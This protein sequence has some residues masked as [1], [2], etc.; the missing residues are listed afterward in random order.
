MDSG[1][2]VQVLS[3][4]GVQTGLSKDSNMLN[5]GDSTGEPVALQLS[6]PP[7]SFPAHCSPGF[8]HGIEEGKAAFPGLDTS[9]SPDDRPEW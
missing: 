8:A 1:V 3:S 4:S 9:L 7:T 6:K 5:L 2:Y